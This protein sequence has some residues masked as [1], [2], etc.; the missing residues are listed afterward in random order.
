[1]L[2]DRLD[3]LSQ[4]PDAPF[5]RAGS[6]TSDL[7]RD[8]DAF[9]RSAGVKDDRVGETLTQLF[10]EVLRVERHGFTAGELER[11]K[12]VTLRDSKRAALTHDKQDGRGIADEI[13][14]NFFEAEQMPGRA[15]E[16]ELFARLL[17]GVTLDEMNRLAQQWGGEDNR[18]ILISGPDKITPPTE[19][20]VRAWVKQAGAARLEP[21]V[22]LGG[23]ALMATT[24]TPGA[25]TATRTID[26]IGTTEWTLSNGVKVVVKPTDFQIDQVSLS[27]FSPGGTS[28]IDD[29]RWPSARHAA[30]IVDASGLGSYKE[31]ELRK[32]LAGRVASASAS[33]NELSESV[34]AG[35]SVDDLEVILQLVHLTFTAPRKD[36]E[37]FAAWKARTAEWV[38]NKRL[39]PEI[40]FG[41]D[42]SRFV[43]GDHLRRRP[44]TLEELDQVDLDT[45]FAIY[46]D[47]FGDA[48]DFTFVIVGNLD[49]AKLQPLVETY[50]ASLPST[51]RKETWKDIKV[52][53]PRGVK[54]KRVALGSE[55][56]AS[57][58]L[59]FHADDKW[60]RESEVDVGVMADVLRIRLR[61]VLREDMGGVYGVGSGGWI[62]RRPN[63]R[64]SF[65]I[66]FGCA[67]E[68]ADKLEAAVMVEI[69]RLQKHGAAASYLDKVRQARIRS[70]ELDLRENWFW[71]GELAE[72]WDYGD[73]PEQIDELDPVLARI[74]SARVKASAR[75]FLD[76]KQYTR[77]VMVPAK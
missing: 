20:E 25:V 71:L 31:F 58:R 40:A 5:T 30:A 47:R 29:A 14:R 27:G 41:E 45:A 10:T 26:S 4:R 2:N 33:I 54:T 24:P 11:A 6:S 76:A 52:K 69:K 51:G 46:Q 67:P 17:P 74:T 62:S 50:L 72:A 65:S 19:A 39:M 55:P 77:G 23:G 56:K 38:E 28:L 15:A 13:T 68:A 60:T 18:A 21:W 66:S 1:M 73:D 22:D 36:P 43:A 70:H 7:N 53:P 59:I 57:V 42:F 16:A 37:A 63:Q 32:V 35:G 3:E 9:S 44:T 34:R 49:L 48:G 61:E 64:R 75:R 12:R 8:A